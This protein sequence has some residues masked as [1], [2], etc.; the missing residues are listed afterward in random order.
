MG[1]KGRLLV[2]LVV[3]LSFAAPQSG[4][5]P[6]P[7]DAVDASEPGNEDICD[8]QV[9]DCSSDDDTLD[10][11]KNRDDPTTWLKD[12]LTGLLYRRTTSQ[13]RAEN[14]WPVGT[15]LVE[16]ADVEEAGPGTSQ[17]TILI[18]TRDDNT[19][20][21]ELVRNYT[22][23][24]PAFVAHFVNGSSVVANP[25]FQIYRSEHT[26]EELQHYTETNESRVAALVASDGPGFRGEALIDDIAASIQRNQ[27]D[28]WIEDVAAPP[29]DTAPTSSQLTLVTLSDAD[30]PLSHR[31]PLG[32][33]PICRTLCTKTGNYCPE[34]YDG[35]DND[36]DN[37]I[38]HPSDPGCSDTWDD[39][40][41]D[42]RTQMNFAVFGE[43]KWCTD[44]GVDN[45]DEDIR[46]AYRQINKGFDNN[47]GVKADPVPTV[48]YC[49]FFDSDEEAVSCDKNGGCTVGDGHDYPYNGCDSDSICYRDNAWN[50]V[51]EHRH[52]RNDDDPAIPDLKLIHI[53]HDGLMDNGNICGRAEFPPG[54]ASVAIGPDQVATTGCEDYVS[55]HEVGHNFDARHGDARPVDVACDTVMRQSSDTDCRKNYFSD[56]S[57]RTINDCVTSRSDCPR[58]G[59]G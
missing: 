39:S 14:D 32:L 7:I 54:G 21:F 11:F 33:E 20:S 46:P 38:D 4:V 49:W 10:R 25:I 59:T 24:G 58:S 53:V 44:H 36:G 31:C 29:G 23:E 28:W 34:C 22:E 47:G 18:P 3:V 16:K 52:N 42:D 2:S 43:A 8:P 51:T 55:T 17:V 27:S 37:W 15:Y 13:E 30:A 6:G 40:E 9:E 48:V 50:D 12:L 26:K 5:L 35:Q 19:E 57:R 56:P 1:R 45:Y 41:V